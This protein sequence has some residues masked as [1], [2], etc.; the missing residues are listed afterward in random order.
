MEVSVKGEKE[1]LQ[2]GN[3]KRGKRLT[4]YGSIQGPGI[5]GP[6]GIWLSV[7]LDWEVS[8][9]VSAEGKIGY[10]FTATAWDV[11]QWKRE[12]SGKG[13]REKVID[14]G[15]ENPLFRVTK[16]SGAIERRNRRSV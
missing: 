15:C 3:V 13:K 1:L 14:W 12:G 8:F 9:S 6:W 4:K 7:D 10:G 2:Y 11:E 16:L 5:P